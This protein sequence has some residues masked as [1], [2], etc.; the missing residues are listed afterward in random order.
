MRVGEGEAKQERSSFRPQLYRSEATATPAPAQSPLGLDQ[1]TNSQGQVFLSAGRGNQKKMP[2]KSQDQPFCY[3]RL[4]RKA[5]SL[6]W[7]GLV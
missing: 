5:S 3:W 1:L 4:M 2:P 7:E 6:F